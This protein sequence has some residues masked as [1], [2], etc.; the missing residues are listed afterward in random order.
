LRRYKIDRETLHAQRVE[1]VLVGTRIGDPYSGER[2]SGCSEG[3]R[4]ESK[5]FRTDRKTFTVCNDRLGLAAIDA[6]TSD[7]GL[8]LRRHLGFPALT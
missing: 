6:R 4:Q 2:L 1:A 3:M 5:D 7:L 8:D